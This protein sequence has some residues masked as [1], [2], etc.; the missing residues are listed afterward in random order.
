LVRVICDCN[1]SIY[2]FMVRRLG[3][4]RL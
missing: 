3:W 2:D 1:F 4:D